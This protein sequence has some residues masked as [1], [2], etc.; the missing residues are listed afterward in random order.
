MEMENDHVVD[1]SEFKKNAKGEFVADFSAFKKRRERPELDFIDSKTGAR[2]IAVV[3]IV[4]QE[5]EVIFDMEGKYANKAE[6]KT[7]WYMPK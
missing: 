3:Q 7:L 4:G 6:Y 5:D 2:P 1:I